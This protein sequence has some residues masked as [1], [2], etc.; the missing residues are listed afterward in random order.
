MSRAFEYFRLMEF[1]CPCC[2]Q[3]RPMQHTFIN[4]LDKARAIANVPFVITSGYRCKDYN[5]YVGGVADSSHT[6]G[7]AADI[8]VEN[9]HMRCKM[10]AALISVGFNRIGI[11]DTFIHVDMD[12]DKP[13]NVIWLY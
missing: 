2:Q 9:S 13:A 1:M 8:Q 4:L 6:K 5:K 10:L 3:V 7:Y 12:P 11:A